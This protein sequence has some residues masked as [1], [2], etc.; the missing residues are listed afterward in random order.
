MCVYV[1]MYVCICEYVCM[2]LANDEIYNFTVEHHANNIY[3]TNNDTSIQII[4][5]STYKIKVT[6]ENV[7]F[8]HPI[9]PFPTS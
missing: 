4:D 2:L 3:D 1:C 9:L 8:A 6:M 7:P 5:I